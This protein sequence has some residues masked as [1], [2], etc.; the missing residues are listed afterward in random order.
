MHYIATFFLLQKVK[1]N[2]QESR[3]DHSTVNSG[4]GENFQASTSSIQIISDHS[5]LFGIWLLN[6]SQNI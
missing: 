5:L 4:I 1:R 6:F 3:A 2:L